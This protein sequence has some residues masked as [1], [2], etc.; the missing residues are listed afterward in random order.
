MVG[1]HGGAVATAV[2]TAYR[3]PVSRS[4]PPTAAF[5]ATYVGSG[6]P[7]EYPLIGL[8]L[9]AAYGAGAGAIFALLVP[10]RSRSDAVAES[11]NAVL[12]VG[13]ALCLSVFG[14]RVL[15]GRL[16][17][18]DLAPDE[19]LVFHASHVVYGLTLGTWL[20]SRLSGETG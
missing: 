18:M 7:S 12:G 14:A 8:V 1:L 9:H 17:G 6:E 15:L 16:L 4:L 19:R 20:G 5:W 11:R 10:G 13:Y 2:M 3:L